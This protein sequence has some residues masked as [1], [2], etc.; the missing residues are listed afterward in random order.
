[1]AEFT[2]EE[3][4]AY[5]KDHLTR[6][7]KKQMGGFIRERWWDDVSKECEL[8]PDAA[9]SE[10]LYD[11]LD[12]VEWLKSPIRIKTGMKRLRVLVLLTIDLFIEDEDEDDPEEDEVIAAVH[13]YIAVEVDPKEDS[14]DLPINVNRKQFSRL[15]GAGGIGAEVRMPVREEQAKQ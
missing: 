9:P 14:G 15:G 13:P 12:K 11:V 10:L 3:L 4:I 5:A 6:S 7:I 2:Q 1:M 8:D